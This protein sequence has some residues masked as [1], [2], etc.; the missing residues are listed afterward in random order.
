V[1]WWLV[2]V[3]LLGGFVTLLLIGL[4]VAFSFLLVNIIGSFVFMGGIAGIEQM[5]FD[6]ASAL[7]NFTLAPIPL[8][9]LMGEIL[10]RSGV[11]F[12]TVNVIDG[13]LGRIPG[14]LAIIAVA[15][16]TLFSSF[17]GSTISNT[18]LL[19]STLFP[20]MRK[21]GYSKTMSIGPIVGSGGLAMMIPPSALAV[22][23]GSTARI[24][25][26]GI[27]IAGI[28]PGLIMAGFYTLYI[29]SRCLLN[30]SLA[31]PYET[32]KAHLSG[33]LWEFLVYVCPLLSVIVLVL[34][35]IYAGIAT[36]TEAAALGCI[37]AVVVAGLYGKLSWGVLKASMR[38]TVRTVTV[39]FTIIA[40]S[41]V[42]GEIIAF[43]GAG[44]GLIESVS[45]LGLSGKTLVLL[46]LSVLLV[47]GLFMDQVAMMMITLPIFMPIVRQF[48][49]EPIWFAIM[50]LIALDIGLTSPPFGLLLF[51]MKGIVPDDVT[52]TDIYKAAMPF[53][54]C[55]A[56]AIMMIFS[57]PR[58][59]LYLP[60]L[61]K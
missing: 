32:K 57:Y 49:I 54:L 55:N 43:S 45:S 53:I 23:F 9:V 50:A 7:T 28:L 16:S 34:G 52:M 2:F 37:G 3:F 60:Q 48:G 4:P 38:A 51:I 61:I 10:F 6:T 58:I 44:A 33:V 11:A 17:T 39:I 31:P 42:Y 19:G 41:V 14:R 47:L 27:L 35:P 15:A 8:F 59:A 5:T 21:K 56:L 20:E 40:G 30:P 1:E 36:P 13:A 26:A 12:K 25:V 46:M 29:T 24:S 18:A 22:L